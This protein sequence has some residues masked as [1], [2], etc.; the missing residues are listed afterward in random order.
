MTG[1]FI[2]EILGDRSLC[3]DMISTMPNLL[4]GDKPLEPLTKDHQ[5]KS[6]GGIH[7]AKI[8]VC[9]VKA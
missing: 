5:E 1:Q 3:L 7:A 6:V 9:V 8:K 2:C 4:S